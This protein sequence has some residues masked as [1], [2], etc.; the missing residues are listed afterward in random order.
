MSGESREIEAEC[1]PRRCNIELPDVVD[2][3]FA[4]RLILKEVSLSQAHKNCHNFQAIVFLFRI[5][6]S[7]DGTMFNPQPFFVISYLTSCY[8]CE[9]VPGQNPTCTPRNLP[10]SNVGDFVCLKTLI[11][12]KEL[13]ALNLLC[14]ECS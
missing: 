7:F 4:W 2:F 13:V 10:T 5:S 12:E 1:S 6:F 3:I 11:D 8:D 14:L 9:V